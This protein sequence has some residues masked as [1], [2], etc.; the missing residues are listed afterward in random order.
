[1]NGVIGMITLLL[2]TE[3]TPEQREYGQTASTSAET[4]LTVINDI[5]DFSK[6]EAG[7]LSIEPIAFSLR[8]TVEE[9]AE[10]MATNAEEQGLDLIVRWHPDAASHVIGDAGRIRQVL[11]NLVSNAL[12]F[13]HSGHVLIN[14][15][16]EK[17]VDQI[18]TIKVSVQDTG[19][20]IPDEKLGLIF[21]K[22]TQADASTTRKYGG[23]GL[24]L[25][26]CK[27]LIELMEGQIG[28]SSRIGEGSTFWFSLPLPLSDHTPAI[29]YPDVE[30]A[31]LRVLI[32]DDNEVNRRVL[33]E[34]IT[35][36]GMRNGG[37]ASGAEA[38][39]ALR[40]ALS[41]GDPYQIAIIDYMMPGM[42]G[43]MLAREIKSDPELQETVLVMLT[44]VSG[45]GEAKRMKDAG[46][47]AHLVK[48]ARQSQLMDALVSAWADKL[49]EAAVDSNLATE[50]APAAE[51]PA[52]PTLLT[53]PPP[54]G[55][56]ARVL[57]VDDNHVNQRVAGRMLERLGC[58]V[59]MAADGR[60]AVE[61]VRTFQYD[62]VFMDCQMPEMDGYAATVQIRKNENGIGH[63]P[64]VAMTAHAMTGDRES[65]LQSGMDD[66]LTKPL[67]VD[68][69]QSALDR[70]VKPR[71]NGDR[72]RSVFE[73]ES[74]DAG[75]SAILARLRE[76]SGDEDE[77][78]VNE[79]VLMFLVQASTIIPALRSAVEVDD[80]ENVKKLA[81]RL[82]GMGCNINSTGLAKTCQELER[83][84]G[85]AGSDGAIKLVCLLETEFE[86]VKEALE[87]LASPSE[88]GLDELE[89]CVC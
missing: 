8:R 48:P 71:H 55:V 44:S 89:S 43:E 81:H 19:I 31:G 9:V 24:G 11:T 33:H 16:C 17:T 72:A 41:A 1:M 45:R 73:N 7:R 74:R 42:D 61:M 14:V 12:K 39:V 87:G 35:S 27:Q 22:F 32:V 69:L 47:A 25:A 86:R 52:F 5:L 66:Y 13:T 46:F 40:N 76:I 26:I 82:Q 80:T 70:W 75:A 3:L 88:G 56:H 30:L 64:I 29:L 18:A 83:L 15:E 60:E 21:D 84:A 63:I 36:W 59:S 20:G 65:C 6:I 62:L 79:M 10:V 34:Q 49:H 57:V 51:T 68:D 78:F 38:L 67:R 85:S 23:T 37:Y 58:Q 4:L 2:D 54:T 28:V 77:S 50:I 53:D